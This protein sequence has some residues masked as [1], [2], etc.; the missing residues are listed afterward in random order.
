MQPRKSTLGSREAT[1]LAPLHVIMYFGPSR[2]EE[3]VKIITC[4][5]GGFFGHNLKGE[6]EIGSHSVRSSLGGFFTTH[7]LP[8]SRERGKKGLLPS[9]RKNI[10]AECLS[11]GWLEKEPP[12]SESS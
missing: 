8:A 10:S 5:D 1:F 7:A 2:N 4:K 3:G 9:M 6:A 11:L 12:S